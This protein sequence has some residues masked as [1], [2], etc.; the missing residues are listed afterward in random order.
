MQSHNYFNPR[1]VERFSGSYIPIP[2]EPRQEPTSPPPPRLLFDTALSVVSNIPIEHELRDKLIVALRDIGERCNALLERAHAAHLEDLRSRHRAIKRQCREKA[3]HIQE[4]LTEIGK[5]EN[6]LRD[7]AGKS[8][9]ARLL[10][11][12]GERSEPV[13]E[14]YPSE[15]ELQTYNLGLH[16]LREKLEAAEREDRRRHLDAKDSAVLLPA[17]VMLPAAESAHTHSSRG[18]FS[19][20]SVP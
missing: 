4:L 15:Q 2:E 6:S 7:A 8:G 3:D 5:M 13:P 10:V 17:P 18:S 11:V 20:T 12:A 1:V 14:A 16:K 9:K 19:K